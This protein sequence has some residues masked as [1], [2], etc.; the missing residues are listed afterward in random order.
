[1][2]MRI[3]KSRL[4]VFSTRMYNDST[5]KRSPPIRQLFHVTMVLHPF[6][7]GRRAERIPPHPAR[8]VLRRQRS[9]PCSLR[10]PGIPPSPCKPLARPMDFA[11]DPDGPKEL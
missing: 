6:S 8:G 9:R 1:L 11:S 4:D 2:Y 5:N 7:R 3:T 10:R